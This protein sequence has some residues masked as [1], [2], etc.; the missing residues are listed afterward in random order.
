[1]LQR[2]SRTTGRFYALARAADPDGFRTEMLESIRKL[3]GFDGAILETGHVT[4]AAKHA[5]ASDPVAERLTAILSH[6]E[7]QYYHAATTACFSALKKPQ[8]INRKSQLLRHE[9]PWLRNLA[10]EN[11]I[12]KILLHGDVLQPHGIPRWL[13]LYRTR[14]D[15]FNQE[16]A[17]LLDACWPHVV[18]AIDI[19]LQYTLS[20]VDRHRA[21][22]AL[23]LINSCGVIEAADDGLIE[24]L[25]SEWP[26][27]NGASLHQAVL[28][29]L[30]NTRAYR[31][32]HIELT[33]FH[34]LGYLVCTG[35][36]LPLVSM[37]SPSE[38]NAV[39][40][41][42]HGMTHSAIAGHLGVSRHTIR[43]QLANAYQKLGIHSKAELIRLVSNI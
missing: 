40:C 24:L 17:A 8:S 14:D 6:G 32:K 35:R 13:L 33:A 1:M 10:G 27:F 39:Q 11:G 15:D 21:R 28:E 36:R 31:G 42:A 29:S 7:T 30:L 12:Q 4:F 23:S 38:M 25:K 26:D 19:N 5:S 18:Q 41:F 16:N 22:R 9:L 20:R 34:N 43:N 2:L 3:I 37:L